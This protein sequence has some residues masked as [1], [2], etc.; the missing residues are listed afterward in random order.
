[1]TPRKTLPWWA[2]LQVRR[3]R[4]HSLDTVRASLLQ[5]SRIRCCRFTVRSDWDGKGWRE[6]K[7]RLG[8]GRD[9]F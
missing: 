7:T 3:Y 5:F 2:P 4:I 8:N 9:F 6:T 1:M